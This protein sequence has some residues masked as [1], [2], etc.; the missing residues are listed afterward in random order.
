M[1]ASPRPSRASFAQTMTPSSKR[2]ASVP[3]LAYP[4]SWSSCLA[5]IRWHALPRCTGEAGLR[6]RLHLSATTTTSFPHRTTTVPMVARVFSSVEVKKPIYGMALQAGRRWQRSLYPWLLEQG[7]TKC[8][9]DATS[10]FVTRPDFIEII[11]KSGKHEFKLL[12]IRIHGL[13]RIHGHDC[14]KVSVHEPS[15]VTR[16]RSL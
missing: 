14:M 5:A 16:M 1:A 9:Y 15:E 4:P 2:Y 11:V 3:S 7:F 6:M 8:H 10:H 13:T 12:R